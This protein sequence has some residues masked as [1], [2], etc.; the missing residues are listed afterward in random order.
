MSLHENSTQ[1][2]RNFV[3]NRKFC[4][5]TFI[6]ASKSISSLLLPVML[7]IF[8]VVITVNQQNANKQQREEDQKAAEENR[9]V[10]RDIAAERYR[11]DIFDAYIKGIGQLF[12]K[13]NG[14]LISNRVP[15]TL[16]RA[17]TLNI[18]RRLDP[19]RNIRIIRFLHESEQLSGTREQI[20]LDL[21]TA[22]LPGI[23]F[24]HLAIYRKQ[25]DN[26]SLASTFLSN[27]TFIGV[28]MKHINFSR[29]RFND[30]SWSS[31]QLENVEFTFAELHDANFL[32]ARFNFVN[33]S[34]TSFD[35]S[36]LS[37]AWLENVN[38]SSASFHKVNFSSAVLNWVKF[39]SAIIDHVNFS[40][41]QLF[42]INFAYTNLSYVDFS[43]A[44]LTNVDFSL[45]NLSNVKFSY[46]KLLDVDFPSARLDNVFFS[47]SEESYIDLNNVRFLSAQ[48]NNV[49]FS[50]TKLYKVDFSCTQLFSVSFS[51]T[52]LGYT[53]YSV[54]FR[55]AVMPYTKFERTR[56]IE[57]H[58][59]SSNLSESIFFQVN[60]KSASFNN[61]DLTNTN[62]S[63]ANLNKADFAGTKVTRSQLESALSI[64]DALLP[65]GTRVRNPNLI[66]NGY[67]DC[68]TSLLLSW[69][70]T[71]GSITTMKTETD[72]NNCHF[73]LQSN[74]VGASMYQK[75]G[76]AHWDPGFWK[77]SLAVLDAKMTNGVSIELNGKSQNGT[78]ID[79][80]I[81]DA[82]E[83]NTIMRLHEDMKELDVLVTFN[84]DHNA[85]HN[86]NNWC[87]EI[88][89]FIDYGT[90]EVESLRGRA[91]AF[92]GFHLKGLD[93]TYF[94]VFIKILRKSPF[95]SNY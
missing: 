54:N 15:M 35:N 40:S 25:L 37:F 90:A 23:D 94:R 21:S 19:Q 7:G 46:A 13:Y 69:V 59:N 75:V 58:F 44:T 68:N 24:R 16:A 77:Y 45:A 72:F 76:L 1:T 28:G 5:V 74:N 34:N 27:A 29:T 71:H 14:S 51:F 11:D 48:F 56:C 30:S 91:C 95:S 65:N 62:F 9:R 85:I 57:A 53:G 52:I 22:E 83:N 31:A 36:N 49:Q 4:N 86:K 78:I 38:F 43:F 41:S 63:L 12:E 50:S 89:L 8:T 2:K 20:S 84:P 66:K 32:S 88:K 17:K 80:N 81:L 39:P 26:I 42:N 82:T 55:N 10:E 87:D 33:F 60:A 92:F 73:A 70:L 67:A 47:S 61:A 93:L 18:F 3:Q 6:Q 79:K 64:Q